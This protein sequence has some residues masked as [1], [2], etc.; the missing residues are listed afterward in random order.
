M[1]KLILPLLIASVVIVGCVTKN[2]NHATDPTQP[3]YVVSPSLTNALVSAGGVA[4]A[5]APVN[6][7]APL[8]NPLVEIIGSALLV[9]SAWLAKKKSDHAKAA[10]ALAETVVSMGPKAVETALK[11]AGVNGATLVSGHIDN[12]TPTQ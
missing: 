7:Y 9:T 4:A 12:N 6:P 1:K 5:T 11:T 10:D 8:T 3:A 2:P